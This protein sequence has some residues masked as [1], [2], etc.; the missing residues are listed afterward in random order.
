MVYTN[1]GDDEGRF[2]C[3]K[4]HIKKKTDRYRSLLRSSHTKEVGK[5]FLDAKTSN[6]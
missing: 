5:D 3:S 1:I 2:Q 6:F 4:I